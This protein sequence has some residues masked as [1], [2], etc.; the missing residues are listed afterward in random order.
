MSNA[1]YS[2]Y[3]VTI[4][5]TVHDRI[6]GEGTLIG[7]ADQT[8]KVCFCD[9]NGCDHSDSWEYSEAGAKDF[10]LEYQT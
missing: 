10:L 6:K 4:G 7:L 8:I 5:E 1:W 3:G 9:G 2:G